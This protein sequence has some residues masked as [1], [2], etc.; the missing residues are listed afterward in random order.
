[1]IQLLT[2][3]KGLPFQSSLNFGFETFFR[4]VNQFVCYPTCEGLFYKFFIYVFFLFS[5]YV[6][7]RLSYPRTAAQNDY[8][9]ELPP[10][11]NNCVALTKFLDISF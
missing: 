4:E 2:N 5:Y 6:L 10:A 11:K 1:M 3:Y 8:F 7:F 9:A